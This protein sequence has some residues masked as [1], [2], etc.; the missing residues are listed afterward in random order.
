MAEDIDLDKIA[1]VIKALVIVLR[2]ID[3][4]ED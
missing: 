2:E 1:E 3:S 4:D